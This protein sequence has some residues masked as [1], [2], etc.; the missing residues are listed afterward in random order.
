MTTSSISVKGS[1]GFLYSPTFRERKFSETRNQPDE[2]LSNRTGAKRHF[3]PRWTRWASHLAR[4]LDKYSLE[5]EERRHHERCCKGF[6]AALREPRPPGATLVCVKAPSTP[7]YLRAVLRLQ[8]VLRRGAGWLAHYS[9][10]RRRVRGRVRAAQHRSARLRPGHLPP[11]A[12][13]SPVRRSRRRL[14]PHPARSTPLGLTFRLLAF[15]P[16][17]PP[18]HVCHREVSYP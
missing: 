9:R 16:C 6:C 4:R 18:F 5:S 13:H 15:S 3:A 8:A 1:A 14:S 10:D 2:S 11:S 17:E 12:H 7:R